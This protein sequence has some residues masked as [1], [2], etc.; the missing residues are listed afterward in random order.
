M[1]H[2]VRQPARAAWR[3]IE[4]VGFVV[5]LGLLAGFLALAWGAAA[6]LVLDALWGVLDLVGS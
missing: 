2:D 5:F 6:L 3:R 1:A 4:R